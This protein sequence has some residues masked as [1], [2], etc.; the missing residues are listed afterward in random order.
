MDEIQSPDTMEELSELMF[1]SLLSHSEVP[2]SSL[3]EFYNLICS[4][5]PN[6]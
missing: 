1:F 5:L 2:A 6:L 4:F 3:Q